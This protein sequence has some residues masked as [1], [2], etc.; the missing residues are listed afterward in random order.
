[1]ARKGGKASVWDRLMRNVRDQAKAHVRVGVLAD[2]GGS[3]RHSD[4]D[5]T[6]S[7]I[8]AI[9][10]YGDPNS[11][12]PERSYIRK[13]LH[14]K[15]ADIARLI[16]KLEKLVLKDKLSV[17]RALDLLGAEV[18]GHIKRTIVEERV[19]GP[20]ITEA[21]KAA[22][23]SSKKLIDTGVLVGAITHEVVA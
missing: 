11:E 10:E 14:D 1:V 23:G 18:A 19:G 8:A 17:A 6:I 7:E 12:M 9:H 15:R 5:L 2:Q 20:D 22:K 4:G 21:T 16:A 13:T 3:E